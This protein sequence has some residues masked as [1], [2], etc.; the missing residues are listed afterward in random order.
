MLMF[1]SLLIANVGIR[2]YSQ[3]ENLPMLCTQGLYITFQ[4]D[5]K[6]YI[7]ALVKYLRSSLHPEVYPEISDHTVTMVPYGRLLLSPLL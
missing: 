6:C 3:N 1:V 5:W 4:M 7:I 2:R